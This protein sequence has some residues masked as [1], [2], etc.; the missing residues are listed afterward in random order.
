M[1]KA[2]KTFVLRDLVSKKIFLDFS[3]NLSFARL[4]V[5]LGTELHVYYTS[6]VPWNH[7]HRL[8]FFSVELATFHL[9][10]ICKM[11]RSHVGS[12]KQQYQPKIKTL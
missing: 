11:R 7:I 9:S 8:T 2:G 5:M 1:I 6:V 3:K 10:P 12:R 4:L